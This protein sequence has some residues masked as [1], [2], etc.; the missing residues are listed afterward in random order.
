MLLQITTVLCKFHQLIC[1]VVIIIIIIIIIIIVIIFNQYTVFNKT[2][3]LSNQVLGD[4]NCC[5]RKVVER[6]KQTM[7]EPS[8]FFLRLMDCMFD[9]K[10]LAESNVSGKN[11][12]R[13]LDPKILL[14]SKVKINVLN[15]KS[16]N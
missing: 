7:K 5:A 14:P 16:I 6:I 12:K 2:F 10:T 9:E 4:G 11:D 3:F 15:R 13:A 1:T 8:Q